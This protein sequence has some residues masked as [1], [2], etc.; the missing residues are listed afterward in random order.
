MKANILGKVQHAA[1]DTETDL[2]GDLET[3]F[4]AKDSLRGCFLELD[5]LPIVLPMAQL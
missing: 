5:I 1:M 3:F 4:L 2:F